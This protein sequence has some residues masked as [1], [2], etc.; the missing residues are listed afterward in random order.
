MRV[1]PIFFNP[2]SPSS[3]TWLPSTRR[4]AGVRLQ[5]TTDF[6]PHR[7]HE[8]V[9]KGLIRAGAVNGLFLAGL[10]IKADGDERVGPAKGE[11]CAKSSVEGVLDVERHIPL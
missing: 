10:T 9:Q 5:Q 4:P 11:W 3:R 7:R 2:R 8:S 1:K 6:A